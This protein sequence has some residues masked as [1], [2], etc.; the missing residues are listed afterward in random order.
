MARDC[1]DEDVRLSL[2]KEGWSKC[3][4]D[5]YYMVGIYKEG[6]DD[7]HCIEMIRCCRMRLPG[8]HSEILFSQNKPNLHTSSRENPGIT[9]LCYYVFFRYAS[10]WPLAAEWSRRTSKVGD[11]QLINQSINPS[12]HPSINKS[13][14]RSIGQSISKS[15]IQSFRQSVGQSVS[16]SVSQSVRRSVRQSVS[17]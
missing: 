2:D 4:Q 15:V 14:S 11:D 5:W 8:T 1:Y 17:H 6:C 16:Q 10:S 13:V 7:L 3:K 12:I 9:F